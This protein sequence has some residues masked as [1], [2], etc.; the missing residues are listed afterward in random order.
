MSYVTPVS[1][2]FQDEAALTLI[3]FALDIR[4][5]L[6]TVKQQSFLWTFQRHVSNQY[7]L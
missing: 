6:G 5:R 4:I 3:I 2:S 7:G 1:I